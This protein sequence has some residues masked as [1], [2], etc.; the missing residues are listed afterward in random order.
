MNDWTKHW[1]TCSHGALPTGFFKSLTATYNHR[2]M[3][4]PTVPGCSGRPVSTRKGF[5]PSSCVAETRLSRPATT[6]GRG[7]G[8]GRPLQEGTRSDPGPCSTPD[9]TSARC[10]ESFCSS[11]AT[12]A[13]LSPEGG[14]SQR[15]RLCTAS[16]PAAGG[17]GSH[18][19]AWPR[20]HVCVP[21]RFG[22]I[23]QSELLEP[24]FRKPVHQRRSLSV[25][26]VLSPGAGP[27]GAATEESE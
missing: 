22:T 3:M 16:S 12:T 25:I 6:E 19:H 24:M 26:R 17:L 23:E 21:Q 11:P 4:L 7:S 1:S 2:P 14:W 10:G 27:H 8:R 9:L 5:C 13:T 18:P 15:P 20:H